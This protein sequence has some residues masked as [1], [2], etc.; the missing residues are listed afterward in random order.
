[1]GMLDSS[2]CGFRSVYGLELILP[3]AA[4]RAYPVVRDV[5]EGGAGRHA[6]LRVAGGR[7]VD[8]AADDA[9]PF[10]HWVPPGDDRFRDYWS[11]AVGGATCARAPVIKPVRTS[12]GAPRRWGRWQ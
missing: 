9:S 4:E 6:V 3:R 7:I 1:M 11:P 2:L 5:L 8:V 12:R 10:F